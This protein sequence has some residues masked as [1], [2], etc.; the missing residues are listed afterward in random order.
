MICAA[1]LRCDPILARRLGAI[2]VSSVSVSPKSLA[3]FIVVRASNKS[4]WLWP[5]TDGAEARS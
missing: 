1:T 2:P 4:G 3:R 5:V